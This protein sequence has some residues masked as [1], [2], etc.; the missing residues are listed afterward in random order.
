MEPPRVAQSLLDT[1]RPFFTWALLSST[2]DRL[3]WGGV[4]TKIERLVA[5]VPLHE[6]GWRGDGAMILDGAVKELTV[7]TQFG[8]DS[9]L[10]NWRRFSDAFSRRPCVPW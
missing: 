3:G 9:P 4:L 8:S 2:S 5:R 1:G 7:H 10:T 6:F